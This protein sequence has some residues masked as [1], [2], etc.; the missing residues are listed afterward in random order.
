M[1]TCPS[2]NYKVG[3]DES[4]NDDSIRLEPSEGEFYDVGKYTILATRYAND[5]RRILGCPK[6]KNI[7]M[8]DLI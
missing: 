1:D 5:D 3:W 2:C 8:G 6:C 4:T 7:F